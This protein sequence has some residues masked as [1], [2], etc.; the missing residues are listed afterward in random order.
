MNIA[1]A[2]KYFCDRIR[3]L[4]FAHLIGLAPCY[5][6]L[7]IYPYPGTVCL[8]IAG[9]AGGGMADVILVGARRLYAAELV[10]NSIGMCVGSVAGSSFVL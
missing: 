5:G 1:P 9:S 10:L 3:W 7:P 4:P 8:A 2:G 6:L